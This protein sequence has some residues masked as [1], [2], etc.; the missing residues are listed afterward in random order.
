MERFKHRIDLGES[1]LGAS[2]NVRLDRYLTQVLGISSRSQIKNRVV[3]VLINGKESKLGKLVKPGDEL[4][5]FYAEPPAEDLQ[6]ENIDLDILCEDDNVTVINKPQGMVVHPA[7]GNYSGTLVNALLY[8]YQK[9]QESFPDE[10]LR[11]GIVHRLDKDTSGVMIVARNVRA[12]ELIAEQFRSRTV[13]KIYIAIL[14]GEPPASTG[15]IETHIMRDP[16][17]RQRFTWSIEG[18]KR[19]VTSYKLIRAFSGYS[20]MALRPHTGRTHQIR[21]HALSIGCPV[22]GDPVYSRRDKRFPDASLM[23]HSYRL[24]VRLPGA[25]AEVR[26]FKSP[27]PLRFKRILKELSTS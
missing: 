3:K 16:R 7:K 25:E 17:M 10:P 27:L 13:R 14:K 2:Q 24:R 5:I 6:A 8:H 18:G 19:A 26:E 9:L 1:H 22:L 12:H 20:L 23:L 21:V 15:K 4:E 11:P